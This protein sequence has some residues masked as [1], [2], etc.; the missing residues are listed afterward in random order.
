MKIL[1]TGSGSFTGRHLLPLLEK[2][3]HEIFYLVRRPARLTREILWDF[4]SPL[5]LDI[6]ACDAVVHLAACVD[7][8]S[9]LHVEQYQINTLSTLRLAAYAHRYNA[10]FIFASMVGVHGPVEYIDEHTPVSPRS[11]YALSKYLAEEIV[12]NFVERYSILRIA[13]IYGLDGPKHLGLNEAISEAFYNKVS[14]VMKGP[15]QPKRNYICVW[16]VARWI[17]HLIQRD[18]SKKDELKN[19]LYLAGSQIMTIEEYLNTIVAVL[20]PGKNL[21]RIEGKD[22]L[23]SI[24]K[25][26]RTPFEFI[27]FEDYLAAIKMNKKVELSF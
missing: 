18:E 3:G 5:P 13:G 19:I 2:S 25:A 22:G 8:G 10:Y 12:K 7:F 9:D 23:D 26:S 14:P 4:F 20:L 27:R 17:F 16:D 11:H 1:L 21:T 15:G 6:P 24:V